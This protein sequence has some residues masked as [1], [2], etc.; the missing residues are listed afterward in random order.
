LLLLPKLKE[1]QL[2]L[3]R[4]NSVEISILYEMFEAGE[5]AL[6]ECRDAQCTDRETV[7]T[8][9]AAMQTMKETMEQRQAG[10]LIH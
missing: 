3:S 9:Y 1:P 8:V 2:E 10:A 5:E 6:R 4:R 7:A